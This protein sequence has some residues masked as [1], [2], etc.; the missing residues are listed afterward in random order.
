MRPLEPRHT[1]G[2]KNANANAPRIVFDT[3]ASDVKC[4]LEAWSERYAKAEYPG[5]VDGYT[6]QRTGGS[7]PARRT[8]VLI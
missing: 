3:M 6:G 7:K 1:A 5:D 8:R 4:F 2:V